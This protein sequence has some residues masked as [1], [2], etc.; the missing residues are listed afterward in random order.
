[1]IRRFV[2]MQ[3]K[4]EAGSLTSYKNVAVFQVLGDFCI[5]ASKTKEQKEKRKNPGIAGGF[6]GEMVF[7]FLEFPKSP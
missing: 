6:C 1:M 7:A 4:G 3:L 5:S 2:L